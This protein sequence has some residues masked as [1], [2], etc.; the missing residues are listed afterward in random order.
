M[1]MSDLW[2]VEGRETRA[3]PYSG[4]LANRLAIYN[5]P[6]LGLPVTLHTR[7]VGQRPFVEVLG[8]HQL[9][10]E[11]RRGIT[12]HRVQEVYQQLTS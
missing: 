5:D 3:A 8:E 1:R 7:P 10:D 11:Q 9:R 4:R 2:S 6:T 12:L